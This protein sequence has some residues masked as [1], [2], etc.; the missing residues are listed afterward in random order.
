MAKVFSHRLRVTPQHVR[1]TL[2]L[3]TQGDAA[4]L[5]LSP[6]VWHFWHHQGRALNTRGSARHS[7]RRTHYF[8]QT[9]LS[10]VSAIA[11]HYSRL[12]SFSDD[13][14][15]TRQPAGRPE[16]TNEPSSKSTQSAAEQPVARGLEAARERTQAVREKV[17]S[18]LTGLTPHEN[19]YNLPNFLTVT[20]LVA[21]P[22]TAYLLLH[23]HNALALGL[24]A[25]A[26]ITDLVDG[27]LARKWKL[28]TVAGSVMDPMAD[29]ALM[30]ILTV[31]LAVKGAIPLYLATL[32]LGRD[33]SLAS[34]ALY[35]RYASLPAPKTFLRYW[36][37]SLPSAEVH[38]TTVSKYNTF[39]QLI[40][41][42]STLALPVVVAG[43]QETQLLQQLGVSAGQ[44]HN[45]MTYFQWL[46]AGTTAWSGLSYAY[47]KNV[48]TILGPNE[49]LKAKQGARG[50]AIISLTFGSCVL[51]AS[52]LAL[53]VDAPARETE[54]LQKARIL[55]QAQ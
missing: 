9:T 4:G 24:F 31:T 10:H 12:R 55:D 48:V 15:P 46:V 30:I 16:H 41:I 20:R 37:F 38:P 5:A 54:N 51:A 26:G 13:L 27:W 23:D 44:L 39:L 34:A 47:L 6:T 45:A 22:T 28:Q 21:A 25:Y 14:K 2:P 33:A 19:I 53:N 7:P 52:W 3:A 35:Y 32:I 42:G 49:A 17:R 43:P 40:L 8:G 18:S 36:D 1:N 50:R 29:K 11:S